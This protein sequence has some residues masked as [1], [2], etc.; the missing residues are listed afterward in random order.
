MLSMHRATITTSY[1]PPQVRL[2][3]AW[4]VS[5]HTWLS[6][7]TLVGGAGLCVQPAARFL[8]MNLCV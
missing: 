5:S 1:R 3:V 7:N 8:C 2:P 6:G 4:S